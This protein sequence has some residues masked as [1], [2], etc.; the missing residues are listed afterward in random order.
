[1]LKSLWAFRGLT[2]FNID[3]YATARIRR[4]T[5]TSK[6]QVRVFV[7]FGIRTKPSLRYCSK[8]CYVQLRRITFAERSQPSPFTHFYGFSCVAGALHD[9][10]LKDAMRVRQ[11]NLP[12]VC[13]YSVVYQ[14]VQ[15][16]S[17]ST[18]MLL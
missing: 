5:E 18:L 10:N 6:G 13:T 17:G 3:A 7:I 16:S 11:L 14:N 1:M 9:G 4:D 15:S 8:I 2:Q 12:S